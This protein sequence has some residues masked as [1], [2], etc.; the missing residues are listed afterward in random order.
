VPGLVNRTVVKVAVSY[1]VAA[2]RRA[3]VVR[4]GGALQFVTRGDP[5]MAL[6]VLRAAGRRAEEPFLG[7]GMEGENFISVA[8]FASAPDGP[9]VVLAEC[10]SA[11]LLA[12]WLAS[13]AGQLEEA[14][15][16]GRIQAARSVETPRLNVPL[17]TMGIALQVE[18]E[19]MLA[20]PW[21]ERQPEVGWWV[22]EERTRRVLPGLVDWC[23]DGPGRVHLF[24]GIGMD[25]APKE[26]EPIVLSSVSSTSE[27]YLQRLT[28]DHRHQ[29]RLW[30]HEGGG[31]ICSTYDPD[32][33][34]AKRLQSV[35]QPLRH[36]GPDAMHA[37]VRI[38]PSAPRL[39]YLWKYPPVTPYV[40]QRGLAPLRLWQLAHLQGDY[41]PDAYLQQV[42]TSAHLDRIGE[43]PPDRWETEEL[44]HDRHLVTARNLDPWLDYDP[45][46]YHGSDNVYTRPAAPDPA[47]LAQA[48]VDLEP[49]L[50]TLETLAQHP[51]PGPIN[52]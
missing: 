49:A 20:S 13:V 37:L 16:S 50:L 17:M 48:R 43:L 25:L 52:R 21:S 35:Q 11:E 29:R 6:E 22:S 46:P 7:P 24:A 4:G 5:R 32:L 10:D 39:S 51:T 9:I 3:R 40:E 33:G 12:E 31:V 42:L 2:L 34:W 44:G 23:L 36:A 15:L 26:V 41:V 8:G 45:S 38:A 1:S 27:V 18:L 30:I 47:T 14:G 28:E 19:E